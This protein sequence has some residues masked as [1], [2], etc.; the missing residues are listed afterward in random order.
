LRDHQNLCNHIMMN[1]YLITQRQKFERGD[2]IMYK[3]K[4]SHLIVSVFILFLWVSCGEEKQKMFEAKYPDNTVKE[5][6][7]LKKNEKGEFQR[8]GEW[9]FFYK[10][11]KLKQS[12]HYT[13]GN[14]NGP[15]VALFKNGQKRE[16]GSY[17]NNEKNGKWCTWNASGQ[18]LQEIEYEKGVKNGSYLIYSADG[19]KLIHG[20]YQHDKKNGNWMRYFPNGKQKEKGSY[21]SGRKHGAWY[22]WD[23]SGQLIENL[24][25][26][27]GQVSNQKSY[28]KN[29]S[30]GGRPNKMQ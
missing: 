4:T 18:I 13:M 22:T 11:G 5:T 25:Y 9:K 3:Y 19:K 7:L 6:G 8:E 14:L 23:E 17:L 30:Y 10:D 12:K 15:Y 21:M 24:N 29:T 26:V 28:N 27:K 2:F 16:S 20:E 1:H